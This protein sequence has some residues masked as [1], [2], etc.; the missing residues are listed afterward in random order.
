MTNE[1]ELLALAKEVTS[2]NALRYEG[3]IKLLEYIFLYLTETT[4]NSKK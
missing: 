1:D 2:S 4:K 3:R